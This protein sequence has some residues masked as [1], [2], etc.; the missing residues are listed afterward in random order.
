M[1][2]ILAR[3]FFEG[4]RQNNNRD[5]AIESIVALTDCFHMIYE[6]EISRCDIFE[7]NMKQLS[8]YV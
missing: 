8:M 3:G 5:F 7:N 2:R 6:A 1:V 4:K